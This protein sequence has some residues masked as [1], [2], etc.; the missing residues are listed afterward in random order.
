M[1]PVELVPELLEQLHVI[2]APQK[3]GRTALVKWVRLCVSAQ[4]ARKGKKALVVVLQKEAQEQWL[5]LMGPQGPELV[6]S[7]LFLAMPTL[8]IVGLARWGHPCL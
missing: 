1:E 7:P 8:G 5:L 3:W 2:A 4:A 6:V